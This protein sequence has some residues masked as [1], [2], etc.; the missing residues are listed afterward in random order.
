MYLIYWTHYNS[1]QSDKLQSWGLGSVS[2]SHYFSCQINSTELFTFEILN[3]Q[4]EPTLRE[5]RFVAIIRTEL[6]IN[7][8]LI[9]Y[10]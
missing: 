7:E 9:N 2:L 1:Q 3:C 5:T 4:I 6:L 8:L 10:Y